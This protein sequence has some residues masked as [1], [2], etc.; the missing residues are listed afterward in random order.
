MNLLTGFLHGTKILVV[1]RVE[2]QKVDLSVALSYNHRP[3]VKVEE[4]HV[5]NGGA[6]RTGANLHAT[7]VEGSSNCD[8]RFEE[9]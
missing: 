2:P 3:V 6:T 1:Y 5:M 7:P 8:F 4:N 9:V